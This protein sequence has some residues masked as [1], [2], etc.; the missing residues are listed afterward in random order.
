MTHIRYAEASRTGCADG[1]LVGRNE[2]IVE[3]VKARK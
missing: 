3:D 2:R 1:Q